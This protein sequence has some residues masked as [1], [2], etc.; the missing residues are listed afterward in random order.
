MLNMLDLFCDHF[1][2]SLMTM[3]KNIV[4]AS[5]EK[6]PSVTIEKFKCDA[7]KFYKS[8]EKLI[9]GKQKKILLWQSFLTGMKKAV[10]KCVTRRIFTGKIFKWP[11]KVSQQSQK[12][13]F[14]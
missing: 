13:S 4:V 7:F 1:Q 5:E 8:S 3:R 10:L 12:T 2:H 9:N 6:F 11:V 14:R